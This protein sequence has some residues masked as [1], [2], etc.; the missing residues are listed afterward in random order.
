MEREECESGK[1]ARRE[2]WGEENM[3]CT[4]KSR[5]RTRPNPPLLP[6]EIPRRCFDPVVRGEFSARVIIV[7]RID[8]TRPFEG[9]TKSQESSLESRRST[10]CVASSAY[11]RVQVILPFRILS[12]L[13]FLQLVFVASLGHSLISFQRETKFAY[14][15]LFFLTR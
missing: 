5:L 7:A 14:L 2:C 6:V 10:R 4:S 8:R 13:F 9:R 12:G 1:R 11:Y 3:A 15:L